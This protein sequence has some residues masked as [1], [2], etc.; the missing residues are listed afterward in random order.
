MTGFE[1]RVTLPEFCDFMSGQASA[2]ARE[3]V[4]E[5]LNDPLSD[6]S[7]WLSGLDTSGTSLLALAVEPSETAMAM[8]ALGCLE[9][10]PGVDERAIA[11]EIARLSRPYVDGKLPLAEV[12]TRSLV[13]QAYANLYG[14]D[15]LGRQGRVRFF[16]VAGRAVALAVAE[17]ARRC[18][19]DS[20]GHKPDAD[21]ALEATAVSVSGTTLGLSAAWQERALSRD[22]GLKELQRISA[23]LA[24][25]YTLSTFAGRTCR[26]IANLLEMPVR[27]VVEA[28]EVA[29]VEVCMGGE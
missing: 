1:E 11:E 8:D 2:A 22:Q 9:E 17:H 5:E 25:V 20:A 14:D 15:N 23:Q 12:L 19:F 24:L 3:R 10:E 21:A 18:L 29:R 26:E 27:D 16:Q 13:D 28:A 6:L 4:A 7:L